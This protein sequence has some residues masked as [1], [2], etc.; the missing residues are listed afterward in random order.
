MNRSHLIAGFLSF[1]LGV[2]VA[3]CGKSDARMP[4]R[5]EY[6]PYLEEQANPPAD[7][8]AHARGPAVCWTNQAGD[9]VCHHGESQ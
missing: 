5:D 2:V 4:D 1:T 8:C 9:Y 6:G 7:P 3:A